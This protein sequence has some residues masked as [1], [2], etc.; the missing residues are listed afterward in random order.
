MIKKDCLGK[1]FK[2]RK[3]E[4]A[5]GGLYSNYNEGYQGLIFQWDNY[6]QYRA[7]I[8]EYNKLLKNNGDKIKN[9]SDKKEC[10]ILAY[11][12][13]K[14]KAESKPKSTK[15]KE[16]KTMARARKST[17]KTYTKDRIKAILK[18]AN[19]NYKRVHKKGKGKAVNTR[20]AYTQ[21]KGVYVY[22]LKGRK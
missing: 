22:H 19:K 20:F 1:R 12:K 9:N 4:G 2:V 5:D 18:R 8:D 13:V 11:K 7:F 10:Q 3:I 17:K 21:S 6:K 14:T 16:A 15:P